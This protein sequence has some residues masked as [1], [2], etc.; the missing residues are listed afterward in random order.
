LLSERQ[1]NEYLTCTQ[2]TACQFN[3]KGHRGRF[4]PPDRYGLM[5]W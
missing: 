5:G 2:Q 1:Y 4:K 3:L